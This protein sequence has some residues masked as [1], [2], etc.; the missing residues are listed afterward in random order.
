MRA[1]VNE[2]TFGGKTFRCSRRTADHLRWTY[3]K[4]K[5]RHPLAKLVVIQGCYNT[6]IAAS[7]G[8]HDY[9]ACLDVRIQGLSWPKAQAFLRACGWA[10]WWRT[11]AQGFSDHIH[12][13][14]FPPGLPKNPT[15]AQVDAAFDRIGLRVGEYV[16]AQVDDYFAH[17]YGLKGQHRAGSDDSW[18]PP[19]IPATTFTRK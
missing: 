5:A 9:D 2:I 10:A 18:F 16:P 19:N 14:S 15:T 8:T 7:A 3:W 6:T 1:P 11:P 12:M 17:A 13:I 4:L